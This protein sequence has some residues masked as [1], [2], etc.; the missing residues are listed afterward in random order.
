MVRSGG[1]REWSDYGPILL[2]PGAREK[3]IRVI[4]CVRT[5]I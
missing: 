3:I 2:I 1:K 4:H 5:E